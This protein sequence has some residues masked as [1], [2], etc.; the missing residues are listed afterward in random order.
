MESDKLVLTKDFYFNR[1]IYGTDLHKTFKCRNTV[2]KNVEIHDH[3]GL[4]HQHDEYHKD[5]IGGV[6]YH[7][8]IIDKHKWFLSKI[9]YGI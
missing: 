3:L 7:F 5:H 8:K 6:V 9:K 2:Y 1:I 4:E